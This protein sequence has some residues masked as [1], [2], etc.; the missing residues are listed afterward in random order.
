MWAI[1]RPDAASYESLYAARLSQHY[2]GATRFCG[3]LPTGSDGGSSVTEVKQRRGLV[4]LF[5]S[6]RCDEM[7]AARRAGLA[8][9]KEKARASHRDIGPSWS[10]VP[11][12]ANYFF[13]R[14]FYLVI[15]CC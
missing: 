12:C 5:W 6:I 3:F 10:S 1:V 13:L 11:A 8:A 15:V 2:K 4:T 9:W 14:L 7:P